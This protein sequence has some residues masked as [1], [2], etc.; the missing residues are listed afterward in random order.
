VLLA[1]DHPHGLMVAKSR[2]AA[3]QRV[4]RGAY[5]SSGSAD[6]RTARA[7]ATISGVHA[8]L[9]APHWFSHESAALLWGLPVWR[10]PRVTHVRQ[11]VRAGARR[12]RALVRHSG[13][14]DE[15]HLTVVGDLPVTDL[16]LTMVDC[17]RSLAPL[18]GLVVAD[19]ALRAGADRTV[20][21]AMLDEMAGRAG[22]ARARAVIELADEGAESA[23]ETATRFVVLQ[24]GLP[25]PQTQLRVSTGAGV[26]WSDLGWEEWKAL[27]E[28][29]GRGKYTS[30]ADLLAEKARQDATA[31][32]GYRM[33]RVVSEHLRDR[34]AL[35]QRVARLLP[36]DV[37]RVRRPHLRG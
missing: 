27:L 26:Y 25:Q 4:T 29:D 22:V 8:R 12:D 28:Y 3:W 15:R 35:V 16:E 32:A 6:G 34:G 13:I 14:A 17:A 31:E 19:A 33:L 2:S 11:A 7:L 18:A 24:A 21:I 37:P 10:T 36:P 23:G 9:V 5:V 20:A 30:T 1:R